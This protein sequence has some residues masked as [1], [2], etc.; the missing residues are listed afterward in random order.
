VCLAISLLW[1][2]HEL[3]DV[4]GEP[5]LWPVVHF[6]RSRD[7]T[8]ALLCKQA[9]GELAVHEI[10]G[11]ARE[12]MDDNHIKWRGLLPCIRKHPLKDGTIGRRGACARFDVFLDDLPALRFAISLE[13][14]SLVRDG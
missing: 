12:A 10:A 14:A 5:T 7:K 4:A 1:Y 6:L 8:Y 9:C 3:H 11:K 13:L 2:S